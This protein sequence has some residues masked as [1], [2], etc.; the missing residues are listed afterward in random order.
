MV[1]PK[2]ANWKYL[3]VKQLFKGHTSKAVK[4]KYESWRDGANVVVYKGKYVGYTDDPSLDAMWNERSD[5]KP[6]NI[7]HTLKRPDHVSEDWVEIGTEGAVMYW[8]GR[9]ALGTNVGTSVH[10]QNVQTHVETAKGYTVSPVIPTFRKELN[11][12]PYGDLG[13]PRTKVSIVPETIATGKSSVEMRPL[14]PIFD[15]SPAPLSK[16]AGPPP[17]P[18]GKPGMAP[19]PPPPPLMMAKARCTNPGGPQGPKTALP[20]S[21]YVK[22][23]VLNADTGVL[24]DQLDAKYEAEIKARHAKKD[25]AE[26]KLK[27]AVELDL[28]TL[29]GASALLPLEARNL[30]IAINEGFAVYSGTPPSHPDVISAVAE[31]VPESIL[32]D[33]KV[34]TKRGACIGQILNLY[35]EVMGAGSSGKA[36]ITLKNCGRWMVA[37]DILHWIAY[38]SSLIASFKDS[39][40]VQRFFDAFGEKMGKILNPIFIHE[41]FFTTLPDGSSLAIHANATDSIRWT[42]AAELL[43]TTHLVTYSKGKHGIQKSQSSRIEHANMMVPTFAGNTMILPA[44]HELSVALRSHPAQLTVREQRLI[45][46]VWMNERKYHEVLRTLEKLKGVQETIDAEINLDMIG[47]NAIEVADAVTKVPESILTAFKASGWNEKHMLAPRVL[48]RASKSTSDTLAKA[49]I[50]IMNK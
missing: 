26:P 45:L 19:P 5:V 21:Q 11:M 42:N 44:L 3:L 12:R 27:D 6:Y 18:P 22:R 38:G 9:D 29:C 31:A 14:R 23:W 24:C 13:R 30:V 40:S 10:V 49:D 32:A 4:A 34:N 20:P 48:L 15:D 50:L 39:A 1:Q 2:P 25:K 28:V 47:Q 36:P 43:P 46:D 41:Y 33:L 7:A 35:R 37:M 8:K 17:P 16:K